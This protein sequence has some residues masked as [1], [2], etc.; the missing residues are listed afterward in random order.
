MLLPFYQ[1]ANSEYN[2]LQNEIQYSKCQM[3][4]KTCENLKFKL[5]LNEHLYMKDCTT[6][7]CL[8][9][10]KFKVDQNGYLYL[11]YSMKFSMKFSCQLNC[12]TAIVTVTRTANCPYTLLD[13]RYSNS[14]VHIQ[15]RCFNDM[16]YLARIAQ[17]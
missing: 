14:V 1:V 2:F 12:R 16:F 11:K 15:D 10:F 7:H 8:E 4:F 17:W 13:I 5:C 3:Q 6:F 9:Y